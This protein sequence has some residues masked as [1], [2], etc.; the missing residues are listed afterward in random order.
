MSE[1]LPQIETIVD[2]EGNFLNKMSG[3]FAAV[4]L[5]ATL[6]LGACSA[7]RDPGTAPD[8]SEI[9]TSQEAP[10]RD[11]SAG[12][13]ETVPIHQPPGNA[14][15]VKS[16]VDKP[17]KYD[18]EYQRVSDVL[19]SNTNAI[20]S[21]ILAFALPAHEGKGD[22]KLYT[23]LKLPETPPLPELNG[24]QNKKIEETLAVGGW[25]SDSAA[26]GVNQHEDLLDS[27]EAVLAQPDKFIADITAA[28]K[29]HGYKAVDIDFEYPSLDQADAFIALMKALHEQLPEGVRLS[30]AVPARPSEEPGYEDAYSK[31]GVVETLAKDNPD[32]IWNIMSYDMVGPEWSKKAG[33]I[34]TGQ[35]I[36]ARVKEWGAR[37][38]SFDNIRAGIPMYGNVFKNAPREGATFDAKGSHEIAFK[39][40]KTKVYDDP[41]RMTSWTKTKNSWTSLFSPAMAAKTVA[42]LRILGVEDVMLWGNPTKEY[43][44][45]ISKN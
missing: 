19:Q 28:V 33:P 42:Q 13:T 32:L 4:T 44:D 22:K 24:E 37:I 23:G 40:V 39:D 7:D 38:G 41:V 5:A 31:P 3:R 12:P 17:D 18:T 9:S 35:W 21:L 14:L 34:A 15:Y 36:V 16:W 26:E 29:E 20:G 25:S 6:A 27:W 8:L 45:A 2:Q 30:L 1:T 10:T 11:P 43:L